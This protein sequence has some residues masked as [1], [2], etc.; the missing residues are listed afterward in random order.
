MVIMDRADATV[1]N[2]HEFRKSYNV[3]CLSHNLVRYNH[4]QRHSK[5]YGCMSK[6]ELHLYDAISLPL[7]LL[8]GCGEALSVAVHESRQFIHSRA[9]ELSD[10]DDRPWLLI[11]YRSS[12]V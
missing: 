10:S 5:R 8:S 4:N 7:A 3:H 11:T 6:Y 1:P 9:R 2:Y 12:R